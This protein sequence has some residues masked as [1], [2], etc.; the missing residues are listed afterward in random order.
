MVGAKPALKVALADHA[1]ALRPHAVVAL[2]KAHAVIDKSAAKEALMD[3]RL[4][5]S[6]TAMTGPMI[7]AMT[8]PKIAPMT[9]A[10]TGPTIAARAATNFPVT[11]TP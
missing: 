8:G 6:M 10:W 9:A 3:H 7:A 5:D 2:H 11:S 1:M 4:T